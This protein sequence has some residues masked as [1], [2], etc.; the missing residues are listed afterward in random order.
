MF[1]EGIDSVHEALRMV[2]LKLPLEFVV[3]LAALAEVLS[4]RS[5]SLYST[6]MLAVA[7]AAR[8]C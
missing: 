2:V 3:A 8:R 6:S 7:G 5:V 4:R 1:V